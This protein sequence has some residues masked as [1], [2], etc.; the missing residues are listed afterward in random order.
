MSH[1]YTDEFGRPLTA[2]QAAMR[3]RNKAEL[4]TGAV[5]RAGLKPQSITVHQAAEAVLREK[6]VNGNA[7]VE[8]GGE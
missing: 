4:Y 5:Q 8:Q 7:P 3:M 2:V 1:P 6:A